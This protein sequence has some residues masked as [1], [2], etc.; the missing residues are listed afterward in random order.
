M[1]TGAGAAALRQW[2]TGD[3]EPRRALAYWVDT[4]CESFLEID[5]DSPEASRFEAQLYSAEFG[6][7]SLFVV[8][9]GA[10]TV[11]RTPARIARSRDA[12]SIL[13]QL[14]AGRALF[15]QHGR[16]CVMREG[17]S[18]LVDC[19]APYELDCLGSTRSVVV[20]FPRTW[21]DNWLPAVEEVAARSFP[22]GQGWSGALSAALGSLDRFPATE[23][24]LPPGTVAEHL[25]GLL[26]LAAGP[27]VLAKSGSEKLLHRLQ[28]TLRE[29]LT[30]AALS[31]ADLAQVHGIS[32]RYVHHLFAVAG[33]T[34]GHELMRIRL[35]AAHR[36]LDD[37]RYLALSIGDVAARCGFLEPSH[38]ARRFRRAYGVGPSEFRRRRE[39]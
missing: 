31:P 8:A 17:D 30:E 35:D 12:Y 28:A 7:G 6:P 29:R 15:R 39:S 20:R 36:L 9:A 21:L 3:V 25:A 5:I 22:A 38:F 34:F 10:Q 27:D 2:T 26:A 23:L 32:R 4:I 14:R 18:V 33:T 19:M 1:M 24:A 37:R 16:E 11:R 13:M